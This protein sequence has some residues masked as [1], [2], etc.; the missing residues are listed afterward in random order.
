M[1]FYANPNINTDGALGVRLPWQGGYY[2]GGREASTRARSFS[3]ENYPFHP[4]FV[5]F[6]PDML[7]PTSASTSDQARS[8]KAE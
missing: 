7:E 6:V 3:K 8:M 5:K 2:L 1:G 4:P